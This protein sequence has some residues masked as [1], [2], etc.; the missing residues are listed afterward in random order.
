VQVTLAV[1]L[2]YT[3][4][5]VTYEYIILCYI[6][7]LYF[8]LHTYT[9]YCVTYENFSL[10]YI[11]I[12][13]FVLHTYTLFCVTYLQFNLRYIRILHF[14]L[15][16][17]ISFCVTYE[18]FILCYIRVHFNLRY[19]RILRFCVTYEY[20][21]LC[22]IRIFHFVLHTS[23]SFCVKVTLQRIASAYASVCSYARTRSQTLI[24]DRCTLGIR[25][26]RYEYADI[27]R[28]SFVIRR[29]Q[30]NFKD[31]YKLYQRLQTYKIYVTHTLTIRT[32]YAGYARHT[33]NT[34]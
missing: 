30:I 34:L 19:I 15:H 2:T 22:Y 12:H 8:V 17:N 9:S 6:L 1:L 33:L 18:Y 29:D 5:C 4:F 26:I 25:R 27:R 31:M 16:T 13:H 21:I 20:F 32:A 11:R 10:Y 24:Y 28:C 23:T 3:S 7:T 14:V